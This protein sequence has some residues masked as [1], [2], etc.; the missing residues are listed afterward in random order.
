MDI[1]RWHSKSNFAYHIFIHWSL[2]K[3]IIKIITHKER[4][5]IPGN[6]P[7]QIDIFYKIS[8]AIKVKRVSK[9][10]L[11]CLLLIPIYSNWKV[12]TLNVGISGL[13]PNRNHLIFLTL[14][15]PFCLFIIKNTQTEWSFWVLWNPLILLKASNA[16]Q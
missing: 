4:E 15:P 13:I 9:I 1:N 12:R 5:T 8:K 10:E 3:V 14:H 6:H 16:L 7:P 11:E 2:F